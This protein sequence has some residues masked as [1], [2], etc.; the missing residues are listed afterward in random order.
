MESEQVQNARNVLLAIDRL[1]VIWQ[2]L[3]KRDPS[4]ERNRLIERTVASVTKGLRELLRVVD[5]SPLAN[6]I[7]EMERQTE[8]FNRKA[9]AIEA[10]LP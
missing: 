8:E 7:H 1:L 4:E 9:D 3:L 5:P 10:D 6:A 2:K